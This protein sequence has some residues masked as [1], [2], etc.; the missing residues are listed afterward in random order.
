MTQLPNQKIFLS[1]LWQFSASPRLRGEILVFNYQ[2]THLPN[3]SDPEQSRRGGEVVSVWWRAG[4]RI[5]FAPT[6]LTMPMT[7]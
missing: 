6:R 3:L 4:F 7:Q 2:I 1:R 5:E